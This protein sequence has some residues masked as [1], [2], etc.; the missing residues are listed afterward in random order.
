MSYIPER[1]DS[2]TEVLV[3]GSGCGGLSAAL[4]AHDSGAN[5]TVIEKSDQIGGTTAI[6]GGGMWIPNN[7][8]N[9]EKGVSD[10]SEKAFGYAKLLTQGRASDELIKTYINTAAEML[11]YM[12]D[13]VGVRV[14]ISTMPDYHPELPGGH[15][16]ENSR[17][18]IP[19]L[20]DTKALGENERFLRR[21]PTNPLAM[22]NSEMVRWNAMGT[23]QKIDWPLV[24]K[25]I[26]EG[27]VAFGTS[28]IGYMYKGCLDRDIEILLNTRAMEL[29]MAEGGVIGIKARKDGQDF[30][31][32]ATK[33]VILASGGFE[34]SEDLKKAFLPGP[35]THMNTV[36]H[37]EGDG[38]KM[39]MTIGA[40]LANM[41]ESWG[42]TSTAVPGEE[43]CG[44]PMNRGILSDR[45][46]PHSIMVNKKGKRFVNEAASYNTM[47][48]NLW[49]CDENTMAFL[50]LPC[51]MIVDQQ[52]RDQ[53]VLVTIMPGEE[54]PSWITQADTIQALAEKIGVDPEGLGETVT[55][56]NKYV[57]DGFDPDFHRG[58]SVYDALWG[59][60]E[61]KPN[62]TMGSIDKTP[63][64][65]IPIY[66]GTLGTKGGPRT[67]IHA[68]VMSITGGVI[69][70]L[71]AAGNVMA[72]VCGPAYWGGGATVGPGMTFG[73]IA[74][75]H[76]AQKKSKA[77]TQAGMA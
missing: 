48:K 37:N 43:Y 74:G 38:L 66:C 31:I 10:S 63:F 3:I 12:E 49:M 62:A 6:G 68:Q 13:K 76:A 23:P 29:V 59:D 44:M 1:W 71:Y 53:Y 41:T 21:N 42:W 33:G 60:S 25:R 30:F 40:D 14:E 77:I 52:Y 5:V 22:R 64:Y 9:I 69:E 72:S 11:K 28:L 34:W 16:G 51:W 61:N 57:A 26:S 67:N 4:S 56:W 65:A 39:A 58:L 55:K 8:H 17:T 73:Y 19:D 24:E 50:N 15:D 54:T 47:F 46:L 35:I 27:I 45:T 32:Q 75:R 36:P 2:E 70:G 20:F 18:V 7:H